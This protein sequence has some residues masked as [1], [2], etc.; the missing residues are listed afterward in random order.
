V[1]GKVNCTVLELTSDRAQK[2][3]FAPVDRR[4]ILDRLA[5]LP[6]TT[7]HYTNEP[8]VR[9]LGPVAQ[10]FK[11]AFNLGSDDQH[12]AT[13]DADGVALASIQALYD[14]VKDRDARIAALEQKLDEQEH[15]FAARLAA[16]EKWMAMSARPERPSPGGEELRA[17]AQP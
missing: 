2:S 8:T 16:V 11:T 10:D 14:I 12:I 4:A 13:V 3:G 7:W 15:S 5:R 9:H 17:Q 1:A 6:L